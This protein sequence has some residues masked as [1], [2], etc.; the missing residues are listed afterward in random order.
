VSEL[1]AGSTGI[2]LLVNVSIRVLFGFRGKLRDT[3]LDW[4]D[5]LPPSQ[6]DRA[7]KHCRQVQNVVQRT[8]WHDCGTTLHTKQCGLLI[9]AVVMVRALDL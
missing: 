9:I 6:L 2:A 5:A 8:Y 4:E 3:V 7:E 1:F